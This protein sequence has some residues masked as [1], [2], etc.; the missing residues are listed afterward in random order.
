MSLEDRVHVERRF[1]RS[2]RIDTDVTSIHAL[3][4]FVCAP[5]SREVLSTMARHIKETGHTAFTWTGPYGTGKSSLVVA[6]SA[7]LSGQSALV[8]KA[9]SIVGPDVSRNLP[10]ALGREAFTVLPVVGR[11][12]DPATVIGEALVSR[13]LFKGQPPRRWTIENT[14]KVL[15]QLANRNGLVLIIDEMGKL[16]ESAVYDGSDI[17]P[18]Q[19]LAE[20]ANRSKRRLVVIGVL[21][22]AF[23]EYAQRLGRELRDEWAKVQGRFVDLAISVGTDEQLELLSKAI[24]TKEKAP[25]VEAVRVVEKVI[26]TNRSARPDLGNTLQA[27]WPLHPVVACLLGPVSRRRFGQNQRSLF[28]FLNSA[29]PFGFQDF[30]RKAALDELYYPDRLWDYLRANLEPAILS[31]PDGHRWSTAV[32]AVERCF[33]REATDVHVSL[34]KTVALIDLFRERSGLTATKELLRSVVR[35]QDA[36]FVQKALNDLSAWSLTLFRKHVGAYAIY[37]GSDFDIDGALGEALAELRGVDFRELRDLAGLQPIL[38]KRHYHDTGA[39]RWFD[40]DLV[41][42]SEISAAVATASVPY[43]SG[44]AIGR[45]LLAIPTE[46]E[47]DSTAMQLCRVAAAGAS[48][49]VVI[50]LSA[51]AS[52]VMQLAR[53]FLALARVQ[54]TRPELI[55]DAV[56]RREVLARIAD[57]RSRLEA[58][59]QKMFSSALWVRR[60][61]DPEKLAAAELS[62]LGSTLAD[63]LFVESPFLRNE[64]LNRDKP[65]SN[66]VAAQKMLLKRMVMSEGQVRLGID[67]YPAEGGLFE[68]LLIKS[69]LYCADPIWRFTE[70]GAHDPCRISGIWGA[71]HRV[72]QGGK[73]RTASMADIYAVWQ[74]APF[75]L[76]AGLLPVLGVAFFLANRHKL[77]FY[78][79]GVFQSRFTELDVDY[80]AMDPKSVHVRMMNLSDESRQLLVGLASV[81]NAIDCG[82]LPKHAEPIDVARGLVRIYDALSPWTKRTSRLSANAVAVRS[83]FKQAADPNKFLFDDIP[84]LAFTH[85]QTDVSAESV[86]VRVQEGL[87]E[88]TRANS[89]MLERLSTMMLAELQ[90]PNSSAQA[91]VDLRA[92]AQNV[93]HL[94]GD[95]HVNALVGRLT[96]F[97]DPQTDMEGIASLLARKPSRDWID[98]DLDQASLNLAAQCQ[99]FIR[100]ESLARV[101]GRLDK[102]HAMAVVVGIEG[103]PAPISGEFDV[104]DQE[105]S[106]VDALVAKL[107]KAISPTLGRNLVLA[108]LAEL[109]ADYLSDAGDGRVRPLA[110]GTDG[111]R[112]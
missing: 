9:K 20:A 51:Q 79:E 10:K 107:T 65:S 45:F 69:E 68:S 17:Y 14:I 75:G 72:I 108:A 5:S 36:K 83:L 81:V 87:E 44:E 92:R 22:Q 84:R 27:C 21:H 64:L 112:R 76:K 39:L 95:F 46:N 37:A 66:A 90:V 96:A 98:A 43:K 59:L 67:G 34:L 16:L 11:R 94:S 49:G 15:E 47:N 33:S 31:S 3:E 32:E 100:L 53:E 63:E 58:D 61:H 23:D 41:P 13:G 85:E 30:L 102:R 42:V 56:A 1:Q 54:T 106:A 28:G 97:K 55:G 52:Q 71:A 74:K 48:V 111:P 103:R 4:G 109:S 12:A 50:G 88:L 77:A 73:A 6:L 86:I 104:T 38:A 2:I 110:T 89:Q 99:E 7:L 26:R 91:L 19:Q 105:R 35:D 18:F 29:E 8:K 82:S 78:R 62:A 60:G 40:V 25:R 101:K 57:L 80:L 24:S 93:L 70:P